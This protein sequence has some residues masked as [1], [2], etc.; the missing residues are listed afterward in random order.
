AR[1]E[2]SEL[3][4]YLLALARD[5]STWVSSSD[6]RVLGS[7]AAAGAARLALVR[8]SKSVLGNGL[9]L[10]GVAAPEEM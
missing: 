3:S 9:Q 6:N 2:P 1:A 7:E 10:L 4:Q 8:C 5:V